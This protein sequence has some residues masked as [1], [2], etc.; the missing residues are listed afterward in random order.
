MKEIIVEKPQ[1]KAPKL[2]LKSVADKEIDR[3]S[4]ELIDLTGFDSPAVLDSLQK[5]KR[6][7]DPGSPEISNLKQML[8]KRPSLKKEK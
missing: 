1:I 6:K 7:F 5:R 4:A 8:M 2:R 3:S